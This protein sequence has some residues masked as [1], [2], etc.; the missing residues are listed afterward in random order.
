MPTGPVP[1][2]GKFIDIDM[3]AL[4][5]GRDETDLDVAALFE[6]RESKLTKFVP[7]EL[8]LAVVEAERIR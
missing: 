5:G 2:P 8:Q 4:P 1:D 3:L 6:R 7:T